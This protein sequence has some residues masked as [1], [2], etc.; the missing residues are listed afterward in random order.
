MIRLAIVALIMAVGGAAGPAAAQ[1][2]IAAGVLECRGAPSTGFIVGSVQNF[3]CMFNPVD[4]PPQAYEGQIRKL[5]LDLGFTDRSVIIWT[6]FAPTRV[7]GPGALAGVYAGVSASAAVG[8]GAGANA[9][10]G[11]LNNS[12]AL[13]PVSVEAQTGVNVAAGVAEF[14]LR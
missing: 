1:S 3:R 6:V 14:I 11:G 7:V 10:V 2:R 4:G 9:L 12:F 13:Q 5:G 8:L